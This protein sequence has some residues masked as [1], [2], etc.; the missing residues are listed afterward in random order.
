MS[1]VALFAV[2]ALLGLS[3]ASPRT[4]GGG[5]VP[6]AG[7]T[8]PADGIGEVAS[9]DGLSIRYE[10][11]GA[12]TPALVF[13]HGWA[14]NRSFW[15]AQLEAF[16]D[17]QRVVAIDLGGHGESGTTRTDW[18]IAALARDVC[19]VLDEMDLREVVLVG[20]SMGAPV[21]IEV[22]LARRGRVLGIVG[23]DALHDVDLVWDRAA[24]DA[25]LS[26]MRRDYPAFVQGFVRELVAPD[27]DPALVRWMTDQMAATDRRV[28]V[29]VMRTFRGWDGKAALAACPVPIYCINADGINATDVEGNRRYAAAYDAVVLQDVGFFPMLERPQELERELRAAIAALGSMRKA[30]DEARAGRR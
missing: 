30:L 24:L 3:C 23:V 2:V 13:V 4:D 8:G 25:L 10:A 14:C 22:A 11:H 21:A 18:S 26:R 5:A 6:D 17:E 19:A 28:A 27:A 7:T 1:R 9:F 20:H 16:G 12:G 29:E 15:R